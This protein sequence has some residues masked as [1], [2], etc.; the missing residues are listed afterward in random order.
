MEIEI[1]KATPDDFEEVYNL[2]MEFATF[3][4]TPEKVMIT[5]E[6]MIEDHE[7]FNCI[8]AS[9]NKNL[10]GFATFFFSY[11]SWSG[12]AIYLDDLYVLEDHRGMG[13][14]TLLFDKV[15]SIG[16][17][18]NCRKIKWQVS[19]WNHKAQEFYKSRGAVIDDV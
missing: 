5:P 3:I 9:N 4:K 19:N 17:E 1:R 18:E 15:I 2:I 11:Y 8:V 13:I 7:F 12:K 14:G 16:K 10:I 6:Q